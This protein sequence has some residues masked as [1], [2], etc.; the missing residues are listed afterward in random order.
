MIAILLV[1]IAL[2]ITLIVGRRKAVVGKETT[3]EPYGPAGITMDVDKVW[4]NRRK[5]QVTVH[6]GSG[7]G[8]S[9]IGGV[10]C[11]EKQVDGVWYILKDDNYSISYFDW[12][13]PAGGSYTQ[14]FDWYDHFGVLTKGHYR[15]VNYLFEYVN[16]PG[17][18]ICVLAEFDI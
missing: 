8:Y 3:V 7:S 5:A 14:V 17:V 16:D 15:F 10:Y 6:N 18:D 12:E 2:I 11:I 1:I 9:G 13:L 4:G